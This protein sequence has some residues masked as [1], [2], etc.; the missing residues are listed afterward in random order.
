MVIIEVVITVI[1]RVNDKFDFL[2][3]LLDEICEPKM[4]NKNGAIRKLQ[5]SNNKSKKLR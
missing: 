4:K 3:V 2:I 1:S 5:I